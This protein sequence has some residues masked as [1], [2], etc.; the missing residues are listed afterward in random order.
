MLDSLTAEMSRMKERG[1]IPMRGKGPN[2][3]TPRNPIFVPYRRNN[4]PAQILQ[5]DRNQDEDQI[6]RAP[7]QNVV[8][9]E[10]PKFT[11][12]GEA[13]ENINYMED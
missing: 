2:D 11:Q 6:I 7:F 9:E 12:E 10:E 4:P 8:L 5:R 3:F 1:Q 13:E